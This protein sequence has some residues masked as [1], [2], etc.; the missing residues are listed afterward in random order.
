MLQE[1][2]ERTVPGKFFVITIIIF[3]LFSPL[4]TQSVA[5]E[6]SYVHLARGIE[7]YHEGR[8][9]EAFAELS[10]QVEINR[11]C[12]LAY[13]YRSLIRARKKEYRLADLSL[14]AAFRD[15][16]GF[17]DAIGLHAYI[18]RKRGNPDEA[19]NEWRRFTEAV[20]VIEDEGITLEAI[21]LP[22][23]YRA[24]LDRNR[25][26]SAAA[27][28]KAPEAPPD[29]V[30]LVS[31]EDMLPMSV[32]DYLDLKEVYEPIVAAEELPEQVRFPLKQII[33]ILVPVVCIIVYLIVKLR[34][35]HTSPVITI[36]TVTADTSEVTMPDEPG[37]EITLLSDEELEYE[38][39][40]PDAPLARS[41][42]L[43]KERQKY[44]EEIERLL[45]KI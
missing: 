45:K 17:T 15:S 42:F 43:K 7:L 39:V 20:G 21:I 19:L 28:I 31:A 13:Y 2:E 12:A 32:V 33:I 27:R 10:A 41:L 40:V 36:T 30:P 34:R 5:E 24:K 18:L 3:C 6:I 16:S 1:T 44:A 4:R 35:V 8:Y 11:Y 22:E 26:E 37:E 29:T 25:S 38:E 14:K 23:E 9:D